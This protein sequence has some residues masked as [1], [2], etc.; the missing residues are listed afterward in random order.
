MNLGELKELIEFC[1]DKGAAEVNFGELKVVFGSQT[2]AILQTPTIDQT[3][4]IEDQTQQIE[5]QA[6]SE[7]SQNLD[8]D[9]LA[10]MQIEDPV[11]YERMLIEGELEDDV[12]GSRT[13]D[14]EQSIIDGAVF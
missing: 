5:T 3:K 8:E 12:S 10:V 2:K 4:A 14:D 6:L 13:S 7:A 1:K 9:D 11:R